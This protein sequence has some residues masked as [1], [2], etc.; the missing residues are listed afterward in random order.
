MHA[1]MSAAVAQSMPMTVASDLPVAGAVA[2]A[3]SSS[4]AIALA[5]GARCD[6]VTHAVIVFVCI[7]GAICS[8]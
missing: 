4:S 5:A 1:V 2:L 3:I 8:A 7:T 6:I